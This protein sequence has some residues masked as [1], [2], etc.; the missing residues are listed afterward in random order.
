MKRKIL[1]VMFII[2]SLGFLF[3]IHPYLNFSAEVKGLITTNIDFEPSSDNVISITSYLVDQYNGVPLIE[4]NTILIL[5]VAYHSSSDA[6]N[7]VDKVLYNG[8][9]FDFNKICSTADSEYGIEVWYM[10]SPTKGSLYTL[11]VQFNDFVDSRFVAV[12]AFTNV[13]NLNPIGDVQCNNGEG[14]WVDPVN[15]GFTMPNVTVN[16]NT[17]S[18]VFSGVVSYSDGNYI[19][20]SSSFDDLP[21]D[22]INNENIVTSGLF[23][24]GNSTTTISWDMSNIWP[25]SAFAFSINFVDPD[26]F[27][28]PEVSFAYYPPSN[29]V[30]SQNVIFEGS[31]IDSTWLIDSVQYELRDGDNVLID[32][33]NASLSNEAPGYAD[34]LVELNDL[35]AGNYVFTIIGT[36]E[37]GKTDSKNFNFNIVFTDPEV[38][39][40]YYPPSNIVNSQ[41]V[42]FEGSIIDSTWLIDSVQYEL[43][44][45]DNVLID[46]GNASLSNEAPGYADWLVELNDLMVG[47]YVFTII[48]TNEKGKTDSKNFNFNIYFAPP[49]CEMLNLPVYQTT[50]QPTYTATCSDVLPITDISFRVYNSGVDIVPFTTI[51]NLTSGNYGDTDISVEFT[52][53][54]PIPDGGTIIQLNATNVTGANIPVDNRPVDYIFIETV[55]NKPPFLNFNQIIP[56]PTSRTKPYI[57]GSCRDTYQFETN[58]NISSIDYRINGGSWVNLPAYDGNYDSSIEIFSIS[59][60]EMSVGVYDIEIRCTDTAGNSTEDNSTN[61]VQSLEIIPPS[62]NAP[63][64]IIFN[65]DFQTSIRN[66][67]ANTTAIWGNG[68]VRLR[69]TMTILETPVDTSGFAGRYESYLGS[70]YRISEGTNGL[71]WY[72]KENEFASYNR[73]TDVTTI[74]PSFLFGINQFNDIAQ[75]ENT[76]GDIL[77]WVTTNNGLLLLD[78]TNNTHTIYSSVE[79][80]SSM[81]SPNRIAVDTRDGRVGA[82]IRLNQVHTSYN[83]NLIYID[84]GSN[85][86][87]TSDDT[88]R[89]I[90]PDSTIDTGSSYHIMLD[91]EED[92]LY[93]S[94]Y[95]GGLGMIYDAGAP[96]DPSND[97]R[98]SLPSAGVII[99]DMA[100]DKDSNVMFVTDYIGLVLRVIDFNAN[101]DPLSISESLVTTI[102]QG[103]ELGGFTPEHIRFLPGPQYIGGQ[104]FIGTREGVVLY[105]NTNG[106]YANVLDDN[107]IVL[108][109]AHNVYP[110]WISGLVID[111]YNRLYVVKDRQ[112]LF[113]VDLSRGWESTNLAVSVAG[114]TQDKQ[115]INH[116]SLENL[117]V[118]ARINTSG[119]HSPDSLAKVTTYL[120]IDDGL[121][122]EEIYVGEK[123]SL[124]VQ[125]YRLQFRMDL[126]QNPGTTPIIDSFTLSFVG[127]SSEPQATQL[128]ISASPVLVQTGQVFSINASAVDE[129]DFTVTS[130]NQ[131]VTLTLIDTSTNF[132]VN[133]LSVNTLDFINGVRSITASISQPGIYKIRVS[134]GILTADSNLIIVTTIPLPQVQTGGSQVNMSSN[135]VTS[136]TGN[137]ESNMED[138]LGNDI[139]VSKTEEFIEFK[140]PIYLP[141]S[142]IGN[143]EVAGSLAV[144]EYTTFFIKWE[145]L[146]DLG[147]ISLIMSFLAL[148]F[149][150]LSGLN[151]G[152]LL[153]NLLALFVGRRRR[154]WGVVTDVDTGK[155]LPLAT[156]RLFASGSIELI[157][158]TVSGLDGTYGFALQSGGDYRL[159]VS[160]GF[161][162]PFI[163]DISIPIDTSG[164]VFDINLAK[165]DSEYIS[166]ISFG[167][168]L[169]LYARSIFT[170]LRNV[171]FVIGSLFSVL[172]V[173]I[174]PNAFNIVVLILYVIALFLWVYSV[175]YNRRRLS[176][177]VDAESGEPIPY[178]VIKLYD[179]LMKKNID[180]IVA[181]P[182]GTF[183]FFGEP[184][185]YGLLALSKKYVFPSKRYSKSDLVVDVYSSMLRVNLK[186]G[187][188]KITVYMDRN[189]KFDELSTDSKS[190]RLS[191][192]FS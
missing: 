59:L 136:I 160:T 114:P 48:G 140:S 30:N 63:E 165:I 177:V 84:T 78:V 111:N 101:S 137:S 7:R 3:V 28:D 159:E 37:K 100:M 49:Q 112:G 38:S 178:A 15:L 145:D 76:N 72:V 147:I 46:S 130:Y 106:T 162:K 23:V 36:N 131:T 5:T 22:N 33:G 44:D 64:Q 134:D 141:V 182:D 149:A 27:G 91:Q 87:S 103:T 85:F 185:E 108:D 156:C 166:T 117:N 10:Q 14:K 113:R 92:K 129:L 94:L 11:D 13:D 144:D 19:N 58:S 132:S 50:T 173:Y 191:N 109:T 17:E 25:W 4:S 90:L 56:N 184:G 135:P 39:F 110:L 29:I 95:S 2:L 24:A 55:D 127:Y 161:Y 170:I 34:W 71:I 150:L 32:S 176:T 96:E 99:T 69:D 73:N 86:T 133:A 104:L 89:W 168:R 66:L 128:K 138:E 18:I 189:D 61:K 163:K 157:A 81:Y 79:F 62:D 75:V 190:V 142:Y 105:Y 143:N 8:N 45:G 118:I 167:E 98:S 60:P 53:P 121:N 148:L 41:N 65:E 192:P 26:V 12:N 120:S 154:S 54:I 83:S 139:L 179:L 51:T 164:F 88:V 102:V 97:V 16:S 21:W 35:M 119:V 123:K 57:T 175:L 126:S 116:V 43:R 169:G 186:K 107:L 152:G 151:L 20:P 122:W 146:G 124:D 93:V 31:I 188:N 67:S 68:I 70:A 6:L 125:D 74:Y 42:I 172:A 1:S 181:G 174:S 40:A 155:P 52:I 47:N 158:N 80:M 187:R 115:F 171:F 9:E 153:A 77:V 82:Y 183:D 180:T